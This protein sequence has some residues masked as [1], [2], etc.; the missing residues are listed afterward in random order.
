MPSLI[1]TTGQKAG[2]SFK[3]DGHPLVG[4]REANR[5]IQLMD[6]KV[7]RRH[8]VVQPWKDAPRDYEILEQNATNG[9]YVNG[10][11]ID[12]KEMLADGD[13][14]LVGETQLVFVAGD[15]AGKID[16]IRRM[17]QLSPDSR[18]PTLLS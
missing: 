6:P 1:I 14:I 13:R 5:D 4:G 18:A 8:F 9:V 10:K 2:V 15:D 16:A 12:Q 11:R 7:S 3:L 17:R